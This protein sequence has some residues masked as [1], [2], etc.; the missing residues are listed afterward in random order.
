MAPC[1]YKVAISNSYWINSTEQVRAK[2][3]GSVWAPK[4][5]ILKMCGLLKK[6]KK[7][8]VLCEKINKLPFLK[9]CYSELLFFIFGIKL[10]VG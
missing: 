9:D 5:A 3:K 10:V 1:A 7:S 2:E 4:I 6:K 8:L